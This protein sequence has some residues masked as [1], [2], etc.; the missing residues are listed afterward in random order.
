MRVTFNIKYH[1]TWGQRLFIVGS[2]A[3]LGSDI[4]NAAKEMNY[5][6]NGEWQLE[7]SLPDSTKEIDY[8]YII[9]DIN[10]I[11]VSEDCDFIH[12][13]N[14]N[15]N[16]SS[17]YL[18]DYWY[19]EPNDR[20]FY[21]SAFSKNL[22]SRSID[23][24]VI[25][26]G[27]VNTILSHLPESKSKNIIALHLIA[28]M[29]KP[30]QVVAIT[31]NQPHLGNWNPDEALRMSANNF[32]HWEILL[33][34]NDISFP[35]EYKFIVKD[36]NTN[37]LCY[38]EEGENRRVNQPEAGDCCI[39]INNTP[40][41]SP[42]SSWK[43]CGTVIPVFSLRSEDSFGIGDIGDIKKLIDWAK[44]TNQ[45]IIQVLPMNDTTRTHTWL[46]S[47]PYSA[48]SIYALHPLYI[49]LPMMGSLKNKKKATEYS[50]IQKSVNSKESLDYQSVEACKTA[51]YHDYFEQE[52][53]NILKDKD[54]K[55]FITHNSDWIIPYAAFSYLR[56]RYNTSDFSK[57]GDYARYDRKKIE[58]FCIPENE[59]YDDF[60]FTFFIQYTLHKQFESVSEYARKNGVILKGDI[61]IGINRDSVEAW[62]EPDYFNMQGQ[63]G[64]PPDDFSDTGQNWSFPT[65]N[66]NTM[67]KDG[68]EWWKKRFRK[69]NSYFDSFRIDHILGFFR[70]WEIPM[71]YIE[72]LCGHFRPALPLSEE[73]IE[74][75]GIIFDKQWT[76]PR[77]NI[78]FLPEIFG[79][80]TDNSIYK[81]LSHTDSEHVTLN[82]ICSTQRKINN[83]FK[84]NEDD[85]SLKIRDGLMLLANEVLF[86][87]DP[88]DTKCYHPRISAYKSYAYSELSNKNRLAFDKLYHDFYFVRH[89]DFWKEA[90]LKR[91]TPLINN[92]DM[93]VC[94][95]DLGMIPASVHEVM[96]K[97]QIFT[98]EL[99][100]TPKVSH[101]EFSNLTELPYHS[102]CTTSTHDMNPIRTWWKEDREKTQRYYNNILR[103]DGVAPEECL[104]EIAEQIILNHLQS[105]SM[106]TIIPLQDWFAVDDNLK[107][108]NA[109][110]ERINIPANPYNYWCYRMH[111]M[112]ETLLDSC[113]FNNKIKSLVAKGKR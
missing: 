16:C 99:E 72:G 66:W 83:L 53:E 102:V 105:P 61:P 110:I 11:R 111:I 49:N 86:L 60:S 4:I 40:L 112:L 32:P 30:E 101:C 76:T 1:T 19:T 29:I 10:G 38:W 22:F 46:D 109:E 24:R 80:A 65:Y 62:T 104:S 84:R 95:E 36:S 15:Q 77:I 28:P 37:D 71:G 79:G 7:I 26:N 107:Y 89:N 51:Y 90:A 67:E 81:Y 47:Y 82:E 63:T 91:L 78:S 75:Y 35:L 8:K 21:T 5:R 52:K 97:L 54:F 31:G 113:D 69:M 73:E 92:T 45:H 98:L 59:A 100:R 85:E 68:F 2:C 93:L 88:Y 13:I 87:K 33:N 18:Y 41:K 56:D 27:K 50:R 12:H 70:I 17:H 9:E 6:N 48:I 34:S 106:L 44:K 58:K 42:E 57:W 3:E 94:G 43:A 96:N 14:F 23:E 74:G 25:N 55:K 103:R 108:H 64:A 20:T 39:T